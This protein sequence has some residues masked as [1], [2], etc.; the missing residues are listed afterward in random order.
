MD[1]FNQGNELVGPQIGDGEGWGYVVVFT[2]SMVKW[3]SIVKTALGAGFRNTVLEGRCAVGVD[4]VITTAARTGPG[5]INN[6]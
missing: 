6:V 2:S 1:G 4:L 5:C 3:V